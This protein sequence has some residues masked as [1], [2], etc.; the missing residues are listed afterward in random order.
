M[1]ARGC[2]RYIPERASRRWIGLALAALTALLIQVLPMLA[3]PAAPADNQAAPMRLM[4]EPL[5]C[6]MGVFLQD[7][8]DYKFADRSLFASLRLWTICPAAKDSP[9]QD[10]TVHNS[11][12]I[13]IS[14]VNTQK[15]DNKSGY[16]QDN[17]QVYWSER[18]L[19]GTFFH[20]WSAKN[21][22]F[23]RHTITFEFESVRSDISNFVI[24]PDYAHSG[25]NPSINNGDWI[26]SDFNL[27]EIEHSYETNFG[28]PN[29]KLNGKGV[30]S[31]I[32]VEI[33][34]HRARI[35]SFMKLCAGVY[36]A[37][38][39]AGMAFLMDVREPDI[40]SGR[41]GLLVGCL[42][43]AIVNMQQTEATLG[44]SEDVTLT[45][46]IHIISIAY[47]LASSLLAMTA[48]LRCEAG[49]EDFAQRMD[50]HIYLP[51]YMSSFVVVNVV[52]IAYAAIIG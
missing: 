34:L 5:T 25:Y 2:R 23:D 39:I 28:K 10:I 19:E 11:N 47:I 21:F 22:P 41:T 46:M 40:V 49:R 51:I 32:K 50:R 3:A 14:E 45:D 17:K 12:N 33:T 24:T 20:N 7:L 48:Y 31:R 18:S 13:T 52:V 35:T 15:V 44:L 26:A 36:A 42:F 8:R 30:Y 43:A 16:F 4:N 37:V 1:N 29:S 38:A 9:L 6:V 27:I